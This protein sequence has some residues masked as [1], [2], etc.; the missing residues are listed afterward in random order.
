[1]EEAHNAHQAKEP[2]D[3]ATLNRRLA[4]LEQRTSAPRL[5]WKVLTFLLAATGTV[6]GAINFVETRTVDRRIQAEEALDEAWDI[7]GGRPGTSILPGVDHKSTDLELAER[8]INKALLL[9]PSLAKA[10]RMHCVVLR[11][12]GR[13][14]E[15][16]GS[17][18]RAVSLAPRSAAAHNSLG[19]ALRDLKQFDAAAISYETALDIDSKFPAYR[20]LIDLFVIE[21]NRPDAAVS[22]AERYVS[23]FPGDATAH[24]DKGRVLLLTGER[25]KAERAFEQAVEIDPSLENHV[26][27]LLS[28]A[29]LTDQE[30]ADGDAS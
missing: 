2:S 21:E 13:P 12:S 30:P 16:I 27:S 11:R 17:C 23:N 19:N 9:A 8:A 14:E 4:D 20:N 26:K 15:A 22:V 6:L 10:H 3:I 28:D 24:F 1:M 18:Q 29:D 7:L 5:Q 25:E